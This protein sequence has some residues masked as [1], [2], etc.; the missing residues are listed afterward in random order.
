MIRNDRRRWTANAVNATELAGFGQITDLRLSRDGTRVGM[1]VGGK[2]V[3]RGGGARRPGLGRCRSAR[4]GSCSPR[5]SAATV[6][7]LDWLSQ[8]VL[9]VRQLAVARIRSSACTSTGSKVERYNTSNLTVPVSSVAAAVSR[10]VVAVDHSG[11]WT[12]TDISDVWRANAPSR[13]DSV[14][15]VFYP[16]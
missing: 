4:R 1:V 7:S 14:R 5:C 2:L 10:P 3:R 11:L 8:D 13:S 15:V 12:A 9:V 16:G 6:Q